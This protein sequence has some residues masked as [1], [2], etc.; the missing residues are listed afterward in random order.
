MELS[1]HDIRSKS[2]LGVKT[3][4]NLNFGEW[5]HLLWQSSVHSPR[6]HGLLFGSCE[7]KFSNI[8]ASLVV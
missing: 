1:C 2:V 3:W 8:R 4:V 6:S 7:P 5:G